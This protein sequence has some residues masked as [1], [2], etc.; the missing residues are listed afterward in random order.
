MQLA[1]GTIRAVLTTWAILRPV[2]QGSN[3]AVLLL[4][5]SEAKAGLRAAASDCFVVEAMRLAAHNVLAVRP[6]WALFRLM[7]EANDFLLH[8]LS[9]AGD[10]RR[11]REQQKIA[12]LPKP[13][14][15]IHWPFSWQVQNVPSVELFWEQAAS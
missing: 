12:P 11:A 5:T 9:T 10:V 2:N 14:G 7:D 6:T 3:S 4:R 1:A 8:R 13:R 15:W